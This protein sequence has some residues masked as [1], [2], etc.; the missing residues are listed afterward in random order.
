MLEYLPQYRWRPQ[1]TNFT[2]ED[3]PE[4]P[5]KKDDHNIDNLGHILLAFDDAPEQPPPPLYPSFPT[6]YD[7]SRNL[8]REFFNRH[9][10]RAIQQA[11]SLSQP[12]ATRLAGGHGPDD[13]AW[14]NDI[15][16]GYEEET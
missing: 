14:A 9:F 13:S 5:R 8:E 10:D 4:K 2:E 7:H 3:A 11:R 6:P 16:W 15:D 12:V 1:R